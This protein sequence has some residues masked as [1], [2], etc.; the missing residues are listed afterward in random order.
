MKKIVGCIKDEG[1]NFNAMTIAL[2]CV[3]NYESLRLE[4]SF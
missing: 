4:E 3:V 2:K 1:S